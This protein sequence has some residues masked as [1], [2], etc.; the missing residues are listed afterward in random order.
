MA[1][2]QAEKC[3]FFLTCCSLVFLTLMCFMFYCGISNLKH[4][5][6]HN[7]VGL[8]EQSTQWILVVFFAF[9]IV[10]NQEFF[11][12][13]PNYARNIIIGFARMDGRTVGIV[14]NQPKVAAGMTFYK[15]FEMLV[16][17]FF[18]FEWR[19]FAFQVWGK[20]LFANFVILVSIVYASD[21]FFLFSL[22]CCYVGLFNFCCLLQLSDI[23]LAFQPF[24]Y[25]LRAI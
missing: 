13:M 5:V 9:Q 18:F 14:G 8:W 10:D 16:H 1:V 15:Y 21:F 20:Q 25:E 17:N 2:M 19:P 7:R 11:E 12:I 4:L 24:R 3:L 6:F 22:C 23:P